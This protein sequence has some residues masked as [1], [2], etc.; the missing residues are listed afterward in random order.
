MEFGG[1]LIGALVTFLVVCCLIF[2]GICWI[3][4]Y[5]AFKT[6]KIESKTLIQPT[7][8]LTIKDNK[9]DTLYVYKKK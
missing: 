5:F 7:I 3:G 1:N 8:K 9:V 2:G 4:G 6:D